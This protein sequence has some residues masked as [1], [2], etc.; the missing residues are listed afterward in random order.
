MSL[1]RK[2]HGPAFTLE[3]PFPE[4]GDEDIASISVDLSP[5]LPLHLEFAP[6]IGW[7]RSNAQW[8][9]REKVAAIR[10]IG[11]NAT[12]KRPMDWMRC[13]AACEKELMKE[14]DSDGGCRKKCHRIM[15]ALR[16]E[17]WCKTSKPAVSS[18]ILK[19]RLKH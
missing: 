12:A 13:Y 10:A 11:I 18:F 5:Q 8:P 19:V 16:E 15:K 1:N 4:S 2:T 6:F 9:S 14:M 17:F 3:I 7:P